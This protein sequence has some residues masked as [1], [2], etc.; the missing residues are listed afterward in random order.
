M[1]I[2]NITK[3]NSASTHHIFQTSKMNS[4]LA[5]ALCFLGI[6]LAQPVYDESKMLHCSQIFPDSVSYAHSR[7]NETRVH[8]E[9]AYFNLLVPIDAYL[10]SV[11]VAEAKACLAIEKLVKNFAATLTTPAAVSS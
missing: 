4:I 5:V 11:V 9:G 10:D 6:A 8:L 7:L 3:L 2:G 1:G